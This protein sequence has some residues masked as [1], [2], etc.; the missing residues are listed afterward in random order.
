MLI[1]LTNSM[2]YDITK[3]SAQKINDIQYVPFDDDAY[4]EDSVQYMERYHLENEM[5][6]Q[7]LTTVCQ[8]YF[9]S[10]RIA[11]CSAI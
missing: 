7:P 2:S 4:E 10:D 9:N 11:R 6:L 8:S 1:H 5:L 3:K